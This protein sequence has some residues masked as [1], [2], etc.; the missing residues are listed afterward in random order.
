MADGYLR[1]K[2]LEKYQH[3]KD[4][5]PPWIKLHRD[6]LRDYKFSCLQDASKLH[7]IMIWVLASQT[8]NRV[9]HDAQWIQQQI[10]A[11]SRVDLKSL[12]NSGFLIVEQG[13][14]KALSGCEHVAIAETETETETETEPP[15]VPHGDDTPSYRI[16]RCWNSHAA[17]IHHQNLNPRFRKPINARLKDG[18]SESDLC[19]VIGEYARLCQSGQAPGHNKWTLAELMSRGQGDWIDKILNG[20]GAITGAR[21]NT[22][23]SQTA[24]EETQKNM[25]VFLGNQPPKAR[26]L[27]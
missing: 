9:P 15:I 7:L 26:A 12:I 20:N 14:S 10:G 8:D 19:R 24:M 13:A 1:V 16:F 3:Y 4:R 22:S 18:Y 17:L 21:P 2:N 5:C 11:K 6:I 23:K 27:I 25:E